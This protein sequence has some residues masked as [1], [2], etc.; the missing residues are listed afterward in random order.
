MSFQP[1][2]PSSAWGRSDPSGSRRS[3]RP[4]AELT[5]S[6]RPSG[7]KALHSGNDRTRATTSTW[8]A[9]S[10]ATTSPAVQ[11]E[12][13]S[14]PSCQ[15]GA[16]TRPRPST[17]TRHSSI[18]TAWALPPVAAAPDRAAHRPQDPQDG[19]DD[20]QD[21]PDGHQDADPGDP[22]DDEQDQPEHE[23]G[24]AS[25]RPTSRG[26]RGEAPG[27]GRRD[28]ASSRGEVSNPVPRGSRDELHESCVIT[29][30]CRCRPN[31]FY[32]P[33]R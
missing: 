8:P 11:S 24:A 16:S 9:G 6:S 10:T 13:Y 15:R 2:A 22:A 27:L 18:T 5:T 19:A 32:R 17:S 7:A 23:H 30:H 12:K 29:R 20:Q 26:M 33:A 21:D 1:D 3:S 25:S 28:A 4:S 14:R 31:L